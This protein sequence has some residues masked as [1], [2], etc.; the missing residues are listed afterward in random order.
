MRVL[1]LAD[2]LRAAGVQ[3]VEWPD[4]QSFGAREL[5]V[6]L[7]GVVLHHT[8]SAPDSEAG[9]N[10]RGLREA[11]ASGV[12]PPR[13]HVLIDRSGLWHV[14]S[15]LKANHAGVGTWPGVRE[16]SRLLGFEIDNS[17][18]GERYPEV[19][20]ASV[21][22][23]VAAVCRQMGWDARRVISHHE[24]APTRKVDPRGPVELYPWGGDGS[25]PWDMNLFQADLTTL[26]EDDVP[27]TASELKV[28]TVAGVDAWF[29]SD[30]GKAQVR[31][32][33]R[34][35][36]RDELNDKNRR[37]ARMGQAVKN[38]HTRLFGW[39]PPES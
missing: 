21:L 37:L 16:Q 3:V 7:W 36:I 28:G 32:L 23:G 4:W 8:A 5:D 11:S 17:G 12:P 15:A 34:E 24:W 10:A 22:V 29:A 9:N 18:V 20:A 6:D 38:L 35:A 25:E 39:P 1:W 14:L 27:N 2:V 13:A 26:L 19:Q 30:G 33:V 31:Q